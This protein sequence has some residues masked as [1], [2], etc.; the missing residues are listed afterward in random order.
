M[1]S[2]RSLLAV[3]A[4]L[5]A[6][7]AFAHTGVHVSSFSAGV[8]HPLTGSTMPSPW[9]QSASSPPCSAGGR[10]GSA[11]ELRGHDADRRSARLL[12][13]RHSRRG[14]RNRG[15]GP[16]PGLDRR[17]RASLAAWRG[18]GAGRQA[19]RFSTAMPTGRRSPLEPAPS[20]TAWALPL[21]AS[22]CTS[23]AWRQAL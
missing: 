11:R 7:P 6:T 14:D 22:R 8:L 21:R 9:W 17:P 18:S 4:M 3:P 23:P 10:S 19:L 5:A 13:R 15:F 2:K 20:G 12:G 16:R 1:T